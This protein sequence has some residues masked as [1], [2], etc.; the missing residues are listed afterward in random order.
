MSDAW[1]N[2]T[3]MKNWMETPRE[4]P[5]YVSIKIRKAKSIDEDTILEIAF[6][7]PTAAPCGNY[8][9]MLSMSLDN[10]SFVKEFNALWA[11]YCNLSWKEHARFK[12]LGLSFE[13]DEESN[14]KQAI[15]QT[16][17]KQSVQSKITELTDLWHK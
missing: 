3:Y 1:E 5:P 4:R 12:N 15:P 6:Q 2:E 7:P 9:N 8:S 14:W 13:L 10:A 17:K 16:S 11:T